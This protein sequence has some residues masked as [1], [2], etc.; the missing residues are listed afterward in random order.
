MDY[1]DFKEKKAKQTRDD[2]KPKREAQRGVWWKAKD[3]ELHTAVFA[4]ALEIAE[5][6]S[7]RSQDNLRHMR[8]YGGMPALGLRPKTYAKAQ[9]SVLASEQ[10]Y[11]RLQLN[12]IASMTDTVVAK[13]GKSRPKPTPITSGG[14]FG[15]QKRAKLLDKFLQGQFYEAGVYRW[16]S[17]KVLKPAVVLGTG[18]AKVFSHNWRVSAEP[19][20]CEELLADDAESIYGAP[21]SLFQMKSVAREVLLGDPDNKGRELRDAIRKASCMDE[22]KRSIL[23]RGDADHDMVDV[24]EAWHLPS[25]P[26]ADDGLHVICVDTATLFVETWTRKT[27]P[28]AFMP[29]VERMLGFYGQGLAER[30]VG[31]QLEINH[32]LKKIRDILHL[33]SVPRYLVEDT[34]RTPLQHIRNAIGDIVKYRGQKPELWVGNTV[35]PELFQFLSD[36]VREGYELEGIS[37]LSARA[38]KP[39][40]LNSGAALREFTDVESERLVTVGQNWEWFHVDLGRLFIEET[41]ALEE[42]AAKLRKAGEKIPPYAVRY[43]D[44]KGLETLKWDDVRLEE[45]EY[46][47][48]IFPT[49]ALPTQ[50]SARLAKLE[51]MWKGGWITVEEARRLSDL[52]DL[53]ASS[54][55]AFAAWEDIEATVQRM[56]DGGAF[57]PP[58]PYQ[59]LKLGL[60]RFQSAYLRGRTMGAPERTLEFF[61]R[62][63]D[64][65]KEMDERI[66]PPPTVNGS[67][68]PGPVAPTMPIGALPPGAPPPL[69][70]PPGGA[71]PVIQ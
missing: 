34:S 14:D 36:L 57:E 51:E 37:E 71:P 4:R 1:R 42:R 35:P 64:Q 3:K 23:P 66:N 5:K 15:M 40:G 45:D 17:S 29:Y 25:G 22:L 32:T 54:N 38:A 27:F 62:W 10:G 8:L 20:L 31:R 63:M 68:V 65:A 59:N 9:T 39:A 55:V 50:P 21:R 70:L 18:A 19:V 33:C 16:G 49:S 11:L 41:K 67:V 52:P 69:P 24:I 43:H 46:V 48:Q 60:Q 7:Y 44:R 6:Q 47:M 58:E 30:H 28:F 53:E 13:V 12:L 61:R 2:E 56:L 26:E